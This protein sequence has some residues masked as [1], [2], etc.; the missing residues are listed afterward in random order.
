MNAYP[1]ACL[2]RKALAGQ[3]ELMTTT[4]IPI[5]LSVLAIAIA[6]TSAWLTWFHRGSVR[7]TVPSMVVF[8]YDG[9]GD[10]SGLD[11]KVMVT[12]LLFSTGARGHAIET[13][14]LR[15]RHRGSAHVFPVWSFAATNGTLGRGGGIF[16]G[17]T[18][19]TGWHHF[20]A[21]GDARSFRF[22]SGTYELD[23]LARA[24][25]W[26]QPIK[27]WTSNL[28]IPETSTPTRHDGTE[29]V[30]FDRDPESGDFVPR[31]ESHNHR[32]AG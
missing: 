30:W 5:V 29:Q 20:V 21:S 16:V 32:G 23:V 24:D 25:T 10:P 6:A 2:K 13:L 4:T 3:A 1:G 31:L 17:M 11:P 12:T 26:R 22:K 8:G 15:L 14:F 18:G 28:V 9:R 19:V 27:L 7:M